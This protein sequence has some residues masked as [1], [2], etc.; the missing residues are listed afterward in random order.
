M[1]FSSAELYLDPLPLRMTRLPGDPR[2]SAS[3]GPK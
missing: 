3:V 1:I 2:R